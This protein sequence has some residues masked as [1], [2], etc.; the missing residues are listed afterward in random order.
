MTE[1][2]T[3]IDDRKLADVGRPPSLQ[4]RI[5]GFVAA[6]Q[7]LTKAAEFRKLWKDELAFHKDRTDATIKLYTS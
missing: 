5:D 4:D 3:K 6:V 2:A 1:A 7:K